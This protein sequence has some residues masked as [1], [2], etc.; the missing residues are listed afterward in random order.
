MRK[1][2]WEQVFA[3]LDSEPTRKLVLER[4]REKGQ[5]WSDFATSRPT[6]EVVADALTIAEDWLEMEHPTRRFERAA[7]RR[8]RRI[9]ESQLW[10]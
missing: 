1:I 10:P 5:S 2:T 7:I 4:I 6:K 3:T 8:V 9:L